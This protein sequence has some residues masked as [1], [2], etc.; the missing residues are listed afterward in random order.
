MSFPL[1]HKDSVTLETSLCRNCRRHCYCC[2]SVAAA[3]ILWLLVVPIQDSA[4]AVTVCS[5][6]PSL[7][8]L[9]FRPYCRQ[10]NFSLVLLMLLFPCRHHFFRHAASVKPIS[11]RRRCYRCHIA[12]ISLPTYCHRKSKFLL[13]PLLLSFCRLSAILPLPCRRRKAK[14]A[15]PLLLLL[16]SHRCCR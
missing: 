7:L 13:P 5:V 1:L 16:L 8:L 12:A 3:A 10:F 15:P 4:A 11:R 6:L 2:L 14:F 9:S